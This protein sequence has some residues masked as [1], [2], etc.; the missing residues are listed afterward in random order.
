MLKLDNQ[1]LNDLVFSVYYEG[2][3]QNLPLKNI[4]EQYVVFVFYPLDFTFV[5]PTELIEIS[6]RAEHFKKANAFVLFIS[7]DSVHSHKAW[8]KMP[9]ENGGVGVLNYPM[10]SDKCGVLANIFGVY[11]KE[12][13]Q[14][15]RATVFYDK[16]SEKLRFMSVNDDMIGR[17]TD[18]MLRLLDACDFVDKNGQI[19][20]CNFKAK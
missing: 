17:S 4:K 18:E 20:P 19:C 5:C 11:D 9:V 12:Q 1:N 15:M 2:K 10:V 16:K 13:G 3:F 6:K 7:S 8:S 14:V